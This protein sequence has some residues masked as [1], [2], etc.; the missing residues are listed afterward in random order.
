MSDLI[1]LEE[2]WLVAVW[3]GMGHVAISA[4][5]YLMAKLEMHLLAEFWAEELFDVEHVE[6]H[7]G[8]VR[9]GRLPRSRL[10]VWKDPAGR[11]DIIVFIGEAQ[12]PAGK[13]AFCRRLINFA[14]EL[15]TVRVFTFAAMATQMHP[16]NPSRVYAAAAD[17]GSLAEMKR[18][19]SPHHQSAHE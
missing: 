11:H 10:F 3:P 9:T 6:V 16:G 8:L 14:R 13:Y 4:G 1:E 2:P 17:K 15:G 12:P 18:L 19:E 7:G 5:Y